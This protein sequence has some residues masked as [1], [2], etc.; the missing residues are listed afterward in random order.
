MN[1]PFFLIFTSGVFHVPFYIAFYY[2][3]RFHDASGYSRHRRFGR[4]RGCRTSHG[5]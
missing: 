4:G 3:P 5:G 2:T 1:N